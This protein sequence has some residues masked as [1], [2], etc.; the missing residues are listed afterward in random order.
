MKERQ[1]YSY[2]ES[3]GLGDLGT[4]MQK[5]QYPRSSVC[6]LYRVE[7]S[8]GIIAYSWTSRWYYMQ[9]N[10]QT[11]FMACSWIKETWLANLSKN[12]SCRGQSSA[13]KY[14]KGRK[15]WWTVSINMDPWGR[16][17]AS[18]AG[19]GMGLP[20]PW[21]LRPS[22]LWHGYAQVNSTHS[23]RGGAMRDF[24]HSHWHINWSSHIV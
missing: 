20:L 10:K 24:S 7:N 2:T 5:L 8:G 15:L 16:H 9:I 6:L 13:H 11:G 12:N 1:T 4:Q 14:P 18:P 22:G 17:W 3:W 21:R 23:S 19:I